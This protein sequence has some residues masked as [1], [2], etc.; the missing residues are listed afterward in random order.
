MNGETFTDAL[1]RAVERLEAASGETWSDH[2]VATLVGVTKG[3]VMRWRHGAS[4]PGALTVESVIRRI[5]LAAAKY[6]RERAAA[7]EP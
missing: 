2:R 5:R 7:G 1:L 4:V 6:E 3:T